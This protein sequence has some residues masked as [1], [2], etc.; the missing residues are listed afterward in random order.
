MMAGI[1]HAHWGFSEPYD[2]ESIVSPAVEDRPLE[3]C[4]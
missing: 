3:P 2:M 4:L 1:L